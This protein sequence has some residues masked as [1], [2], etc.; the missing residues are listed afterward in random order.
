MPD[1]D[2]VCI[3][4][5]NVVTEPREPREPT[6]PHINIEKWADTQTFVVTHWHLKAKI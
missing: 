2:I 5:Y 6:Q 1:M 4:I 3:V